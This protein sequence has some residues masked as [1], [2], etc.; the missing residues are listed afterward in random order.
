MKNVDSRRSFFKYMT[1]LGLSTIGTSSLYGKGSKKRFEYQDTPKNG[2]KCV[3]CMH[4]LPET[5]EC[6]VIAGSISPDGW[7]NLYREDPN[8]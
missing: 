8:K 2:E 3:N 5:N 7:C 4:F 1:I 6:K